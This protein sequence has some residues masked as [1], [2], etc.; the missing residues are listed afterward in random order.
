MK[1]KE[2]EILKQLIQDIA[3]LKKEVMRLRL[4]INRI[5][6]NGDKEK[7]IQRYCEVIY[8]ILDLHKNN[9]MLGK[10]STTLL[11]KAIV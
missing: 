6:S 10:P 7:A 9:N 8:M 5:K 2:K 1:E 3:E 11:N 4:R